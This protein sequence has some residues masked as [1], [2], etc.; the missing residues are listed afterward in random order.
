MAPVTTKEATHHALELYSDL[1]GQDTPLAREELDPLVEYIRSLDDALVVNV[2]KRVLMDKE[3]LRKKYNPPED[4]VSE[5]KADKNKKATK[6]TKTT[7][8]VPVPSLNVFRNEKKVREYPYVWRLLF[9]YILLCIYLYDY[10]LW[11]LVL[12]CVTLLGSARC[13]L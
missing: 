1:M 10:L 2:V 8:T 6:D 5:D 11:V 9:Y 13:I 7:Q 4:K 3:M 12:G